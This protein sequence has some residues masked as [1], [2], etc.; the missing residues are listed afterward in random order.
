MPLVQ[1][2]I[3]S[4]ILSTLTSRI[5]GTVD[6][7]MDGGSIAVITLGAVGLF[8]DSVNILYDETVSW[9]N[10]IDNFDLLAIPGALQLVVNNNVHIQF[11]NYQSEFRT[12][13]PPVINL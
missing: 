10:R 9:S 2:T 6:D 1:P 13:D 7:V 12:V 4:A 8:T 3:V 5:T 11:Y